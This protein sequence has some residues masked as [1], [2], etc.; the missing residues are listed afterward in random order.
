MLS[1]RLIGSLAGASLLMPAMA[2]A[3]NGEHGTAFM[4]N[5]L[6][7]LSSPTHSLFAL[8]GGAAVAAFVLYSVRKSRA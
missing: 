6:H 8:I 7:W 5:I 2:H 3:H 4:A 1:R